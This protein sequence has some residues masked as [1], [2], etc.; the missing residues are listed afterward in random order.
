MICYKTEGL[1]GLLIFNQFNSGRGL[2]FRNTGGNKIC[3]ASHVE[4]LAVACYKISRKFIHIYNI[5][6]TSY[7]QIVMLWSFILEILQKN[8]H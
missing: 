6:E 5:I 2:D 8:D 1:K 7:M 4:N 3:G